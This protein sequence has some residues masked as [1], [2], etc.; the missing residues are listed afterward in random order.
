MSN[1]KKIQL[2]SFMKYRWFYTRSGKLVVGGKSA[3]QNDEL[4][5]EMKEKDQEHIVMH[6]SEP[7]SPFCILLS[8]ISSSTQ[9]DLKE[10]AIF[11]GCFSRAWR[12]NKTKTVVDVFRL[13]QLHKDKTMHQGT[14]GVYGPVQRVTVPLELALTRQ[15]SIL[16]A[17]PVSTIKGKQK[18]IVSICP[19]SLPKDNLLPKLEIELNEP[20]SKEEVLSALPT[21]GF[22]VCRL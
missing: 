10:C 15:N 8:E 20:L 12:Q 17:V 1:V 2:H 5:K 9:E 7:G 4:L 3:E 11:T 22:R 21:G 13:S 6:T 19:G 18:E 14:W 16:R